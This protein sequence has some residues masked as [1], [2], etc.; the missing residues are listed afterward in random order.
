MFVAL[1]SR[2]WVSRLA[3]KDWGVNGVELAF[4]IRG[5]KKITL[6][7]MT[8]EHTGLAK[9]DFM[10]GQLQAFPGTLKPLVLC[11]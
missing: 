9:Q 6:S 4:E 10:R 1:K 11:K 3:R 7:F 8:P 2:P 5:G